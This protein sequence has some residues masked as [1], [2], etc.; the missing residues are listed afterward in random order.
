MLI[1]RIQK[2]TIIIYFCEE[3]SIVEVE[4]IILKLKNSYPKIKFKKADNN[5]LDW[6]QMLLMSLCHN[7]IIANSTFSWW[8]AYLNSNINK[9]ICYP[10][11]WFMPQAKKETSDLFLED[12]VPISI[13][14]MELK[15]L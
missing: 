15:D 6:E 9:I 5:L 11:L 12:W 7:N 14:N 10:D 1:E 3:E 2:E 4:D 8:G 13:T